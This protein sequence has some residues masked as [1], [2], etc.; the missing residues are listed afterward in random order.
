ME[1]VRVEENLEA[2]A[3]LNKS[4]VNLICISEQRELEATSKAVVNGICTKN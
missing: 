4:K 3:T 2:I 1:Q